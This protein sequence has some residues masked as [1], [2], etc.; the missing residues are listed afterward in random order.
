M[1]TSLSV[2]LVWETRVP[3]GIAKTANSTEVGQ[4]FKGIAEKSSGAI[5]ESRKAGEGVSNACLDPVG[6]LLE[7]TGG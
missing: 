4:V 3:L 2:N 1:V 5:E 7:N 6:N